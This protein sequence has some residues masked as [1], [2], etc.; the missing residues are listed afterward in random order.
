MTVADAAR[1]F[2]L[3]DDDTPTEPSGM[4]AQNRVHSFCRSGLR[5]DDHERLGCCRSL[6]AVQALFMDNAEFSQMPPPFQLLD[7]R[8]TGDVDMGV[9]WGHQG[10]LS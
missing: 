8:Y 7:T 10:R 3:A 6:A 9:L 1:A 4:E 2:G 5:F